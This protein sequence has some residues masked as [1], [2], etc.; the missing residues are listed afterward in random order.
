MNVIYACARVYFKVVRS[1]VGSW[2][3]SDDYFNC[4]FR[5]FS[6]IIIKIINQI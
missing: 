3:I 4:L 6:I 1:E 5:H 2:S